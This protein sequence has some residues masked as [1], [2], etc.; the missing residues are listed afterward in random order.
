MK[1]VINVSY[2]GFGYGVAKEIAPLA[3]RGNRTSPQL[4][5]LVET[6]PNKCGDL[7]VVEIPDNATDWIVHEYDGLEEIIYVMDGKIHWGH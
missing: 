6:Q 4:I 3:K 7:R 2:G 1:I 5:E